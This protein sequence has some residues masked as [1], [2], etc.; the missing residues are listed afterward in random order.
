L[1]NRYS[2]FL[3]STNEYGDPLDYDTNDCRALRHLRSFDEQISSSSDITLIGFSKGCVVLN[4]IL[5]ELTSVRLKNSTDQLSSLISRF[6]KM[7]WLDGGHNNGQRAMIWPT[8]EKLLQTLSFYNIELE[9]YVTPFQIN[10]SNPYKKYH[11][12]QYER[13][14]KYLSSSTNTIVYKNQLFF[15][16][17]SPSIDKHFE[18][19]NRF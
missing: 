11:T 6:R 12:E 2:N 8:D 7:I 16:D 19:L 10:S 4:Q 17:E 18:L 3:P 5:S 1:N 15:S 14:S 13:L 9:L